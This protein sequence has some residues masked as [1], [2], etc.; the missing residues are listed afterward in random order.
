MST[1]SLLS[2]I[3]SI[4]L[5]PDGHY[6]AVGRK[7]GRVMMWDV[8]KDYLDLEMRHQV[9]VSSSWDK[10]TYISGHVLELAFSPDGRYLVSGGLDAFINIWE[11]PTGKKVGSISKHVELIRVLMFSQDGQY[12]IFSGGDARIFIWDFQSFELV[13]ECEVFSI[14]D[15]EWGFF[16]TQNHTENILLFR[17]YKNL[18]DLSGDKNRKIILVEIPTCRVLYDFDAAEYEEAFFS[19]DDRFLVYVNEDG[20]DLYSVKED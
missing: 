5:S 6:L 15:G 12:L 8:E 13:S 1:A 7:D 19:D 20:I 14:P 2:K 3:T 16:I 11:V 10:T 17:G 18:V 4:A 9:T